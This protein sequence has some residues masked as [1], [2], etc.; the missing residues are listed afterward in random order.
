MR[1]YFPKTLILYIAVV[2]VQFCDTVYRLNVTNI[3]MTSVIFP[4]KYV[5]W[6]KRLYVDN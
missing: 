5:D 2:R 4:L 3:I 6:F 1:I